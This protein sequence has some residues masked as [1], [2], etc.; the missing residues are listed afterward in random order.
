MDMKGVVLLTALAAVA[1]IGSAT[2]V[3]RVLLPAQLAGLG[4]ALPIVAF[5]A[6]KSLVEVLG[7][8]II[9]GAGRRGAS[10]VGALAYVAGA[11]LLYTLPTVKGI[12]LANLFIGA[13][14]GLVFTAMAT[15]VSDLLGS[16]RAA[17]SI[18]LMEAFAYT[19]YGLGAALAGVL[20][21]RTSLTLTLTYPL[22][23]SIVALAILAVAFRETSTLLAM[24]EERYEGMIVPSLEAYGIIAS[25]PSLLLAFLSAHLSKLVDVAVWALLPPHLLNVGLGREGT[26][27]IIGLFLALWGVTMPYWGAI[28]DIIGRKTLVA[29]SMILCALML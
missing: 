26:G 12:T 15:A 16:Q 4:L 19:G 7:G 2:G 18:G 28:S 1:L 22:L 14:E 13:G 29:I 10:I 24:R 21:H 23:S 8:S 9:D 11:W 6:S 27:L 17:R 5:G 3:Q 20:W 25:K